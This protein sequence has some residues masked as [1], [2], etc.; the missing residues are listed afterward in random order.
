MRKAHTESHAA[1]LG[2]LMMMFSSSEVYSFTN[3]IQ[4]NGP[5]GAEA[6]RFDP[7]HLVPSS[8]ALRTAAFERQVSTARR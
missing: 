5:P 2:P 7:H 8:Q 3:V 6:H 1:F 4:G